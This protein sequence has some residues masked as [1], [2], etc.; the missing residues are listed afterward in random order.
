[1]LHNEQENNDS[2]PVQAVP[3]AQRR[4]TADELNA[5]LN[6]L[7]SRK[8]EEAK[9]GRET[10]AIGEVVQELG[11]DLTPEEIWQQIE[12]QRAAQSSPPKTPPAESPHL[13]Q[14]VNETL[15]A[16]AQ[17]AHKIAGQASAAAAATY[18]AAQA[19]QSRRHGRSRRGGL[20]VLGILL[21]LT[22]IGIASFSSNHGLMINGD[23]A[24]IPYAG[25]YGTA[26]VTG[27]EDTITLSGG[28]DTLTVL[29]DHDHITITGTVKHI[30]TL[31]DDNIIQWTQQPS[32]QS[33]SIS[34]NG[35]GNRISP[36]P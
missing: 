17:Q 8:Q 33:P 26:V 16:A 30:V 10:V 4:V 14:T 7:E 29:G 9:Q 18:I 3:P 36:A 6:A 19:A 12:S 32:G 5:A 21:A 2:Q 25:H 11:L 15:H 22:C 34:D 35:D 28:C 13:A 31:G 23:H 1:M 24:I 27:D 20:G